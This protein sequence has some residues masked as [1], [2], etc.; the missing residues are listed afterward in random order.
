MDKENRQEIERWRQLSTA[1]LLARA[2]AVKVANRSDSFSFCSII[3]AKS[4]K[5]SEDCRYC[6][7]SAHYQTDAPIYPLKDTAEIVA[8]A[9]AAKEAGASRFSMVTSG[10]GLTAAEVEAVAERFAAIARRVEIKLCGSFGIL[11][12]DALVRL[13]AAGMCRYHHNLETSERFFPEVTTTHTFADRIATIQA[14]QEAGLEV[15]AGGIFGL[16][17]SEDDRIEMALRLRELAVDSVPLNFLIP[18]P[19][20][21]LAGIEPLPIREIVR[22]I[23]IFRL[24]LPK[25]CIRLAGGRETALEDFLATAFQA[26]ADGM[27]IGGYLTQRGRSVEA[28]RKFAREMQQFWA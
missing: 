8:A 15:C 7:Q 21:P 14:A 17:E 5:C 3:N 24:L 26:G 18:L 20:T 1:E 2:T 25:V 19:G 23:A 11:D 13:K 9:E 6:V 10:R 22:S 4:G 12:R 28:D 27:M 16:G